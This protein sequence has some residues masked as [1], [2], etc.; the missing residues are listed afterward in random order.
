M[1]LRTWRAKPEEDLAFSPIR[2]RFCGMRRRRCWDRVGGPGHRSVRRRE[3]FWWGSLLLWW[4]RWKRPRVDRLPTGGRERPVHEQRV[5]VQGRRGSLGLEWLRLEHGSVLVC[6]P[7][8]EGC[9]ALELLVGPLPG[10]V[11]GGVCPAT[12]GLPGLRLWD[13]RLVQKPSDRSLRLREF[14]RYPT[15]SSCPEA[16]LLPSIGP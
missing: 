7:G 15:N 6:L 4:E 8:S 12:V 5:S 16:L 3:R 13:V 9:F 11:Q 14:F 10:S 2:R 1:K